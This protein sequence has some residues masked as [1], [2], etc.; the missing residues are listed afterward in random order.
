M[1]RIE[2][3]DLHRVLPADAPERNVFVCGPPAMAGA[4][5]RALI[6]AGV[7]SRHLHVE[8]FESV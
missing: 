3:G 1:P 5:E 8:R 4:A 2:T 7:P 6:D